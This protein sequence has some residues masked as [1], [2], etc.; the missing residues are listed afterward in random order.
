VFFAGI[1]KMNI[2]YPFPANAE[3]SVPHVPVRRSL[4]EGGMPS[5]PPL[6]PRF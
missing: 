6:S 2:Y 4:G 3:E 5:A 1:V